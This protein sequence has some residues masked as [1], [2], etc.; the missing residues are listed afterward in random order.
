M[1]YSKKNMLGLSGVLL[2]AGVVCFYAGSA[3]GEQAEVKATVGS[4]VSQEDYEESFGPAAPIVWGESVRKSHFEHAIHTVGLG[5]ECESC[6]DDL[7]EMETGAV[8]ANEDFTMAGLAEG[9]Y[10]GA[11][12]DGESAFDANSQCELC[13]VAPAKPIIFTHPV[14]AVIF[15]HEV[16][17]EMGI[18]C[19]DCHKEF[20]K[21]QGGTVEGTGTFTMETIYCD[22]SEVKYCGVCH[23]GETAFASNTRCTVCHIGVKGFDRMFGAPKTDSHG[24]G[25]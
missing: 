11:C 4:V 22:A 1:K 13:H 5:L 17:G 12:H 14:K 25:H 9:K 8:L 18:S 6:H 20:F 23:D 24:G 7:F 16:H 3:I 21:M 15:E 19:E 10:C 2:L